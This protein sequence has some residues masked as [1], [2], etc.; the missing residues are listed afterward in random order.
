[1]KI[2]VIPEDF[3]KDQYMLKPIITAMMAKLGKHRTKVMICQDPLLGGIS[4]ALKWENIE[5]IIN[6]YP[7]VDLFLLCVDRDG[8]EGRKTALEKIEEKAAK[9]LSSQRLL[10]AENAWHEI[11]VWV[12]AGQNLPSS[13]NWQD[14]RNEINPKE[15]YFLPLSQQRNLLNDPGEGRKTLAE[16]AAKRYDRIRKLC[17]EDIVNLENKIN[18]YITK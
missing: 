3:R 15:T 6:Q 17:P 4:E 7:M 10:L 8:K 14:I 18:T 1:M 5:N 13:W 11:E 12:L 16:E 9:I 2:L